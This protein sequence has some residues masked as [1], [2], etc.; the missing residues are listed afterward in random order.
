MPV[1]SFNKIMSDLL[2]QQHVTLSVD[3]LY[4]LDY[5]IFLKLINVSTQQIQR[6]SLHNI[7]EVRIPNIYDPVCE[8][9]FLNPVLNLRLRIGS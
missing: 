9:S 8:E 4:V 5:C 3:E 6:L 1:P 2:P 7:L